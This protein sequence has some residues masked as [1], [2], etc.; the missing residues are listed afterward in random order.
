MSSDS[1]AGGNLVFFLLGA[2]TGAA[3]ALL[4]APQEGTETRRILGEKATTARD[5]AS[6]VAQAA[7]QRARETVSSVSERAQTMVKKRGTNGAAGGAEPAA[8]SD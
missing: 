5:R 2:A 3:I 4:Y 1:S 7:G 8:D 6:N